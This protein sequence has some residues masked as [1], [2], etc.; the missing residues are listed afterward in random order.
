MSNLDDEYEEDGLLD[1]DEIEE[2]LGHYSKEQLFEFSV[3]LLENYSLL[4]T[5]IVEMGKTEEDFIEWK[6]QYFKREL[7]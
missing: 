4:C 5:F 6:K 2:E 3:I 1:S 7:H